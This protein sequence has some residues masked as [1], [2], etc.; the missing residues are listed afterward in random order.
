MGCE[1]N[2]LV[3]T[4]EQAIAIAKGSWHSVYE[5]ASWQT[6]YADENVARFEPYSAKLQGDTWYV[7]GTQNQDA[8]HHARA[9]QVA[10]SNGLT[11]VTNIP[12][13]TR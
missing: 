13:K 5:E 3:K 1:G 12:A 8:M 11:F 9:A 7:A 4:P 2:G 6:D 10:R